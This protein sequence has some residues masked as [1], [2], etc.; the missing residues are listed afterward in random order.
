VYTLIYETLNEGGY[1]NDKGEHGRIILKRNFN[2]YDRK[3]S[4][5]E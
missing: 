4:E 2:E 1:F 3:L 5:K